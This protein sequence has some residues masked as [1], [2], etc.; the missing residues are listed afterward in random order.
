MKPRQF[1][2]K[3]FDVTLI[4]EE[5]GWYKS[6][7]INV[8]PSVIEDSSDWI[9]IKEAK[10]PLFTTHDK[11]SIYDGDNYWV[12]LRDLKLL[13]DNLGNAKH[14]ANGCNIYFNGYKGEKH[15]STEQAAQDYINLN[16]P[17]LSVQDLID[18]KS[19]FEG[20]CISLLG[21]DGFEDIDILKS[22][23]QSKLSK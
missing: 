16:F 15:F 6:G 17:C 10:T 1:K 19:L 12:V 5:G 3:K 20:N 13:T 7:S 14:T 9:E 23:A 8:P 2:H 11:V 18:H 21:N 4:Q 22:I